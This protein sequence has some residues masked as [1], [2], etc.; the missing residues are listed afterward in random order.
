M[1]L[2]LLPSSF[3][4]DGSASAKQHLT[5]LVVNER[6][7]FDA[8]SLAMGAT[9]ADRAGVRDIV[10]SHAHLDHIAGL[11]LYLDDLFATL[12]EPV[13]I[14][15]CEEVI[16]VVERDIFNWSVYP[17]FSELANANGPVVEYVPFVNGREFRVGGLS[18]KPVSVNHKV[19]SSGFLIT[20]GTAKVALTGDTSSMGE[21]WGELEKE[22][23]LSVL[24]IECAFPNELSELA[25]MSYHLTPDSL[26]R[27][28]ARFG[29]PGCKTYVLNIKPSYRDTVLREIHDLGIPDLEVLE[30]GRTYEW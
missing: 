14:H 29:R 4:N 16:E 8:G 25:G 7:A 6:V 24:L 13:R 28:L 20:D 23:D 10:L 9:D 27:E 5:C 30:V 12:T 21:F 3:E 11:P 22:D 1:K 2:R 17:R 26:G 19:P 18:V 15:A